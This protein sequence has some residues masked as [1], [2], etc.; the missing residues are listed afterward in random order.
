M[1]VF[2]TMTLMKTIMSVLKLKAKPVV[3]LVL[4][5]VHLDHTN[6]INTIFCVFCLH[7]MQPMVGDIGNNCIT[8]GNIGKTLNGIGLIG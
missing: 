8:N 5:M 2:R 1:P 3:C 4:L 6:K 7:Y